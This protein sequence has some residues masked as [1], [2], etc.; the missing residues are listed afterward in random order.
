MIGTH[1]NNWIQITFKSTNKVHLFYIQYVLDPADHNITELVL[2][3][4]RHSYEHFAKYITT[5]SI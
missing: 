2:Q 3:T 1:Y 5:A 4:P